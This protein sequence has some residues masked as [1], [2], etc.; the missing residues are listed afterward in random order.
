MLVKQYA[1]INN[2]L[3]PFIEGGK[4]CFTADTLIFTPGGYVYITDVKTG[5]KVFSVTPEGVIEVDTVCITHSHNKTNLIKLTLDNHNSLKCTPEHWLFDSINSYKCAK[6]FT[7]DEFLIDGNGYKYQILSIEAIDDDYAYTL[8][9]AKN[10]NFIAN[11]FLV[12]NKGGGKG[13]GSEAENTLFSTDILFLTVGVSEGPIYRVN[14]NGPQDIEINEDVIDSLV[15]LESDGSVNTDLFYYDFNIGSVTQA[16]LGVFGD[17]TIIP[18]ASSSQI[19]LRKGNID[20]VPRAAVTLQ[21]TSSGVAFDLLRFFFTINGLY[22]QDDQGNTIANTVEIK[23]TVYDY[24]GQTIVSTKNRIV[25]GKTTTPTKFIIE[26]PIPDN[27][28]SINGHKFTVEKV[29]DDPPDSKKNDSVTFSAWEEIVYDKKS[30]PRTAHIGYAIKATSEYESGTPQFTSMIKGII[31]QVPSNYNQPTLLNGEIDWRHIEVPSSYWSSAGYYQQKTG[32]TLLT[33]TPVIYDGLWDGTFIYAWTQNPVWIVYDLLV[34]KLQIPASHID[35][36]KFYKVAQYCDAVDTSTGAFQGVTGIADG[37]YRYKPVGYNTA[38]KQTLLGLPIGTEVLERRFVCDIVISDQKQV[39][40]IINQVTALFRAI[41]YYSGGKI[42]LNVDMPDEFPV[43]LFNETNIAAESLLISGGR[44]SDLLTGIEV[45]YLEPTNHYRRDQLRLDD[46]KSLREMSQIENVRQV[47]LAGCTRRSMA[48]RLG[49]Y[50]L[51]DSKYP[52]RKVTF[53]TTIEAIQL[54]VGDIIAVSQRV[55]GTAWGYG[56]KVT[57]NSTSGVSNETNVYLEY[58]TAPSI[59]NTIFTANSNPLGLRIISHD[60]DKVSTYLVSNSNFTLQNTG[61]VN[62]GVDWARVKVT[63]KFNPT[64]KVFASYTTFTT[65][66]V[67]SRNDIWTFGE[68]NPQNFYSS[69]IDKLFK[70]TGLERDPN[71]MI[72]INAREYINNVYTDSDSLISYSPVVYKNMFSPLTAPPVPTLSLTPRPIRNND[73]SIRY[74]LDISAQT[75]TTGY[76][77]TFKTVVEYAL[78]TESVEIEGLY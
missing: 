50:L 71:E 7:I 68:V 29:S 44:E 59:S 72:T 60:S 6:N 74:D 49:Q 19:N 43:M 75:D 47:D 15:N 63:H 2:K 4:A 26:I 48:M 5:D 3:V 38:V 1:R 30:Y 42:T 78:P 11:G 33:A 34:N 58:F 21:N 65:D 70:I 16:P 67:P 12:H 14:P 37:G 17:E 18:Q 54:T 53:K 56:G 51:A 57:A 76:P 9:I 22:T 61:N 64:T 55:P 46:D 45:S 66:D 20:G 73:G 77:L 24:S 13:G 41:L 28:K 40:D 25:D 62:E 27:Y 39:T 69:T 8:S 31:C 36:Y 35:K 52:R 23:V 10:P 32:T